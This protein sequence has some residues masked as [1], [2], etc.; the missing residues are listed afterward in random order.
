[1][2]SRN[3]VPPDSLGVVIFMAGDG[4][5][6]C[7][8]R[9]EV[10][11]QGYWGTVC[12]DSWD[13]Q[14]TDVVCQQ[15]GCGHS[16]SA[17]SGAHFGTESGLD[18]RLVNGGDPCQG[19]V[20]VLYRSWWGTVCDDDWDTNDANV[21]CR[22]LDC[23]RAMSAPGSAH[24]G[25]GSGYIFLDD[26]RCSGYKSNLWS[27]AHND[28]N[29][30]NC[31]HH[32]DAGVICSGT[33]SGLALR[34]VNGGDRCQGR[35][36]VLYRGSWGTV[37]DDDWDTNDANVVCRQLGCGWATSAP[38]SAH[39]GQ[40][41]GPIVLD[42]VRCSGHESYLWSCTHN[43]WNSHNCGHDEDAGVV[44]SGWRY[45]AVAVMDGSLNSRN[46]LGKIC[47]GTRRIFTSPYNR[48]I[49]RFP[50]DVGVQNTGYSA[51]YNPFARD[52]S[53]RLVNFNSSSGACAGRVE[54]YH[55][56]YWGTVCDDSWDIQD[57]QVVCRQLGC[58]DA[59]SALGNAYFGSG[60]GPITLDDVA[61]SGTE[62]TLWQCWN[63]GWFSHYCTHHEDAGVI[64]SGST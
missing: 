44:C 7:Q 37:C 57:A 53:L 43:G 24:F 22:Q 52:A 16:V 60:S 9:V 2:S 21:V 25:E 17:L 55:G 54:I 38:G 6:R 64:C 41:S 11:D 3:S 62:S 13:A 63:R 4:G 45:T 15:L 49:F 31:G 58:G 61:C 33:E 36:E 5:D 34:L 19:R 40:G 46:L 18:L 10:L 32:E 35:V 23:G 56:G 39:F 50:S 28:W 14:D 59:V 20:E 42:D 1:M 26:V 29:S 51:W 48:M 27:R 47:N 12:D 8:G 30:H